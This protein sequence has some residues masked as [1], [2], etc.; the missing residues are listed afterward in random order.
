MAHFQQ[1]V[2][3]RRYIDTFRFNR[4]KWARKEVA[5]N[6]FLYGNREELSL[7]RRQNP[8]KSQPTTSSSDPENSA[9]P[10]PDSLIDVFGNSPDVTDG[11]TG[12][13]LTSDGSFVS[14][15]KMPSQRTGLQY[16]DVRASVGRKPMKKVW[17]KKKFSDDK[18]EK[19]KKRS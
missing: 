5:I 1:K 11:E 3:P 6:P 19:G 10:V 16:Q 2:R 13:A 8:L 7:V 12:Q 15:L 4:K 18:A 14:E 17:A 9:S